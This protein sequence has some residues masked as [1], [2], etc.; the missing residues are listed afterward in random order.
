ML[1]LTLHQLR[2]FEMVAEH[3]SV[4]LAA[5]YLHM[6]QPAVSNIIKQLQTYYG[7]ALIEVVSRQLSL[8]AFGDVL[9]SYCKDV[10]AK[11]DEAKAA[12]TA[13]QGGVAG[14][15]SVA[16]VTTAKYFVPHLLGRFKQQHQ[17]I[18]FKLFVGN[19]QEVVARLRDNC[20][21]FVIMSYPPNLLPVDCA[22]FYDDELIIIASPRFVLP[23]KRGLQLQDLFNAPWIMRENGSGTRY[24]TEKIFKQH[25]FFPTIELEIGDNEAV[26]QAVIANIGIAVVSKESVKVEIK[27]KRVKVLTV[28]EFPSAHEWYLVKNRNK[29]LTPIAEKFYAFVHH[30]QPEFSSF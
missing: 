25:K 5:Q 8:T 13:L 27:D 1:R 14:T 20:D 17:K 7:C 30:H 28:K 3:R 6:T 26:K 24:A 16:S 22:D 23:K 12:V 18:H 11:L 19:R 10:F 9:L 29:A 21:D 4:T 2:V 15:L